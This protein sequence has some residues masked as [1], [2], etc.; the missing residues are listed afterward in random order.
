[1]GAMDY[2]P[3]GFEIIPLKCS[4]WLEREQSTFGDHRGLLK[5]PPDL[6]EA[7]IF[8]EYSVGLSI[9]PICTRCGFTMTN[10]IQVCSNFD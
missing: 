7:S 6:I 9:R 8:D 4:V 2:S 10:L 1:M 5:S 3:P